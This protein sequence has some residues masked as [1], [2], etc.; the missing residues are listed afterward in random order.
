MRA[1]P[2]PVTSARAPPARR[3]ERVT[4][5]ATRGPTRAA[6]SP[7]SSSSSSS[8]SRDAADAPT[9]WALMGRSVHE[10]HVALTAEQ[11]DALA[12]GAVADE[13]GVP[14]ET[15]RANIARLLALVPPLAA[16]RARGAV[17]PAALVRLALD[18]P[19]VAAAVVRVKRIL[20][21]A[22][23]AAVCAALPAL[24][25]RPEALD[26]AEA[27]VEA[28]AEALEDERTTSRGGERERA[29]GE[30]EDANAREESESDSSSPSAAAAGSAARIALGDG[31]TRSSRALAEA[32]AAAV[33]ALLATE[34]DAEVA[35][36]A[37]RCRTLE[38]VLPRADL[39]RLFG[40]RPEFLTTP[41]AGLGAARGGHAAG[42]ERGRT[43]A[44]RDRAMRRRRSGP[45]KKGRSSGGFGDAGAWRV[46]EAAAEMRRRMPR[47]C[48]V[49]RL[50]TDFPGILAMDVPAM[51]EDLERAF[52]G[53]EPGEVL[54]RNPKIAT[55]VSDP[56]ERPKGGAAGEVFSSLP[57]ALLRFFFFFFPP[58][59]P[60]G[61][62][63]KLP[64][65]ARALA[66]TARASPAAAGE[67]HAVHV[68]SEM[69][70][71]EARGTVRAARSRSRSERGTRR[72]R[73]RR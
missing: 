6:S 38:E 40:A 41:D 15:L 66:T 63:K 55:Q 46:G 39:A 51:F 34:T 26:R 47:D 48:D 19:A 54:R 16:R 73:R 17:T 52:P 61:L 11:Q 2:A 62:I 10:R 23:A 45:R 35:E 3:L 42:L 7:S 8:S 14:V 57:R 36:A 30:E 22:D 20:P 68:A 67:K 64:P 71:D 49:D 37:R 1:S 65:R 60:P 29:D 25:E 69:R 44:D 53:K 56:I 12:L 58:P 32:L 21:R 24:M 43:V 5:A 18:L 31:T 70:R 9:P 72:R 27:V 50:L 4:R 13:T 33:P 28:L 59:P